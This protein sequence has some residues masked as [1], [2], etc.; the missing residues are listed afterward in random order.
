[1]FSMPEEYTRTL[2]QERREEAERYRR[3]HRLIAARRW[4]RK[5]EL[6]AR[7]ARLARS[8]AW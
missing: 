7:R 3:C 4:E 8:T 2:Q 5:A 6:T 1:M